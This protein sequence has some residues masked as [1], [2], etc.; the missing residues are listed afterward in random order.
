MFK[1]RRFL[2]D[3]KKECIIGPLCKLFEAI[4]ELLVPMVMASIIDVGVKNGDSG[5]VLQMGGALVLLG[6]VG[7]LSALV[8]QYL[9]SKASQGVGTKIRRE[10]FAHINSL[11]HAELDKLGTPSLITRI[12]N[13]VNQVQQ[14]IAMGIRL[15]TRA[16]FIVIGALVMAMTINLQMSVIFF[17]AALLI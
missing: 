2:K 5:Y 6:V 9:A 14:S 15:L 7:L 1:L 10:L 13:D 4:L 17:I 3:Y 11:S 16:P 8:C 12:T